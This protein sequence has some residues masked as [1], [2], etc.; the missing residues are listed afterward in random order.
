MELTGRSAVVTGGAGGL[1]AAT[2]RHLVSLGVRTV[3]FDRDQASA[4]ALAKELGDEAAAESIVRNPYL[5]G[6]NIR[7][8][9]AL[10]LP[11]K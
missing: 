9:G 2:V 4:E 8:D 1:G 6:E 3:V 11:P 7:L 10:R 5:N